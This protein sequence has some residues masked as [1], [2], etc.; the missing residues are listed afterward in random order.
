M[1]Q[2]YFLVI[3]RNFKRFK[4]TFLI[5][6]V[7]LSFGL[8][9]AMLI[10][11]W[12]AGELSMDKFHE[13]DG[14]LYQVYTNQ[15]RPDGIVT[16]GE[17]PALLQD[18]LTSEFP[19]IES[20]AGSSGI[21]DLFT[22]SAEGKNV[23]AAG[24]FAGKEFFKIFTY[25]LISGRTDQ[26]LADKSSIVLS[27]RMATTLF[28]SSD[29][30]IG[31]MVEWQTPGL[32]KEVLVSGVFQN[33]PQS[34][35]LQFDFVLSYDVYKELLGDGL[36]WG[37]FNAITYIKLARNTDLAGFNE[38][39]ADFIRKRDDKSNIT[40]FAKPYSE[41][42]LYGK[43]EN[44]KVAGGRIAYVKLFAAI[45]IFIVIIACINF[46]NL[47]T[48][49]A[50]RRVKEVGIKKAM[51]AGRRTLIIQ[52][53]GESMVMAFLSM[54]IGLLLVDIFLPQFNLI[55]GKDLTLRFD[56]GFLIVIGAITCGT[57]ILAGSYPALYLSGFSP[58]QVLKARLNLAG[59][60][61]WARKGLVIFQFTV[62][63][64]F[65]VSVWVVYKQMELVQTK[66]L[67][68]NK[69]NVISFKVEGNVSEKIDAFIAE[70]QK[71]PGVTAASAMDGSMVGFANFTT[72]SFNW[73]GMDP[74]VVYQFEHH[75]IYYDVIELLGIRMSAGRSFRRD[76]VSDNRGIIFNETAI[77]A[78]GLEDPIGE[79]FNLWGTD[80]TIIGVMKDFNFQSLHERV[81]PFFFRLRSDE[82]LT[83]MIRIEAG[84]EKQTLANIKTFYKSFNPGYA[85]DYKF[86]DA[87]YEAQYVAEQRVS[88][89]SKYF[90]ALSILISCLGLFGL[91]SFTAER[92]LKEI[93]IRKVLGSTVR[94]IVLLLTGEFNRI[95]LVAMVI[96]LPLS[97]LCSTFWLEEFAYRIELRWWYFAGAGVMALAIAWLTAGIQAWK[98]AKINPVKC[99]K[100]E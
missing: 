16:L 86:L 6:L 89:L 99:L 37:N 38:R 93:G 51:G 41:N 28:G 20:A 2:H 66:N 87:E 1:I 62:A 58:V 13:Y 98:A 75:G 42:Y 15:N 96:G 3:L 61:H 11:L 43:Y 90:S 78:M 79:T 72:G 10:Y 47:A 65:I 95:L 82:L 85:F 57:G 35:S 33:V 56:G 31:K 77:K 100:D 68:Y 83:M 14:Q 36:H 70:V 5:N 74:K 19:E 24:Q 88:T 9:C 52:Y 39:V 55:T 48:A 26:V 23:S 97:Y 73:K 7:G 50:S 4:S 54:A 8:A 17:G 92:R 76:F 80:Y 34:S 32:R 69:D 94:G 27:Q 18:A 29:N 40:I 45:G 91:A 63:I 44:G 25:P 71:M 84:K 60:E 21:F 22:L 46:M 49:K 12:V 53:M 81:K 64:V 59:A 30:V 67:G